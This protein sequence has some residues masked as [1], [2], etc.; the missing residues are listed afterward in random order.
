MKIE[1][2]K[3][4]INGEGIGY[5][6]RQPVFVEGALPSEIV[7]AEIIEKNKTYMTAKTRQIIHK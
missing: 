2:K 1:I 3:S 7:E 4:G 6:D 5:V